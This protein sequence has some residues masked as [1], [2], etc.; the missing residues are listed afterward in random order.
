MPGD[1]AAL[2][3][4]RV[5][6][7][8]DEAGAYC[9]KLLADMGADVVK[10]EPPHG[11]RMREIGPFYADPDAR[12]PRHDRSIFFWHYQTSKRSI[13][14]DLDRLNDRDRFLCLADSA[15][16]VIETS[17]P[18][19]LDTLGLSYRTLQARNPRL[20]LVSITPFG[21]SGPHRDYRGSDLIGQAAG[22]MVFV[23]GSPD[24]PPL[25]GA[26]LQGYH[27][28]S[29]Y[30]AI[31]AMLALI[32][33]DRS[34]HG[35]WIDVSIQECVA[36][37]VEHASSLF[38]QNGTVAR[39]QGSLHWTGDFRV[40][41]CRDGYVLH[42]PLGDWTTLIEWIKADGSARELVDS[43]WDDVTYRR[44]HCLHLFDVLDAW[45]RS[46][47]A[48]DL[49]EAAQLRRLPYAEVRP[50][51]SLLD[52]PQLA[53]RGFFPSVRHDELGTTLTYPG[54][55]YVFSATPWRIRRRPPRL[56]EHN[57]EVLG[58]LPCAPPTAPRVAPSRTPAGSTGP[59]L[60]G[61]RVIDFTWMVAGP[62]ATRIL[63]DHGAQVIKI[64]RRDT[65]D[66]GSRRGG[67]TGNLNRGKQSIVLDMNCAPGI[68]LARRLMATADVVIDNFSPRVM[69]NWGLDYPAL[70]RLKPDI[71]AASLSGFG[72]TG[73]CRDFVSYGPTLQALAGYTLMMR[74]LEG[75]PAGWGFSYSDMAA[76]YSGAL[77][78]LI[79]LWHRRRT[80]EGQWI[81]LS[82]FE[83][84]VSLLGPSLLEL[85]IDR[86]SVQ[87]REGS[88]DNCSQEMPSAPHGVYRCADAPND[89]AVRERWCA[90]AVFGSTDWQRL[91]QALGEPEWVRDPRF[92]TEASRMRH[93][94]ALDAALTAWTRQ[95]Q[96][97]A[98]MTCLQ[99]AG[100]AAAVVADAED[101]CRRDPHLKARS[102]WTDVMTPEGEKV[103]LDGVPIKLS[104][105][106][107]ALRAP[108]PK[109]GGDT[110]TILR[111]L[112]GLS[113]ETIADLRA[114]QVI[115]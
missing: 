54:A 30:G 95:H 60:D 41:R 40:G 88:I 91:C 112:L 80:G 106:S 62:V 19:H 10:V 76:G 1:G 78:V 2:E 111:T 115:R 16:I 44:D 33:R 39:R 52:H 46:Y 100:V 31:G 96:A 21:Q 23:N 5:L 93:R 55:P 8:A 77:A 56:G 9:G 12:T 81:D 98:I 109:L 61:I 17:A 85:L 25:Q 45:A 26:G 101:L 92:A 113:P 90:I 48:A 59:A 20:T 13:T 105:N 42:C 43:V 24:Q 108:A 14:L 86:A 114:A 58:T 22:G 51:T 73:P 110:A 84:L 94:A 102:Y 11:A 6:D 83:N 69:A 28:A 89:R 82:Q 99:H 38:H 66:F 7:L 4:V 107:I 15:D 87:Q 37:C 70:R 35:Q 72:H 74:D 79:A 32:A 34:G 57:A 103:T 64:E 18:G 47:A 49:V 27:C 75:E 65:L 53:A 50:T 36:A 3:D 29:V 63:A 97:E 67:L 71:I 68:D 104:M